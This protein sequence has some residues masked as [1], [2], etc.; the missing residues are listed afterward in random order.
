[1]YSDNFIQL[2][3]N[4]VRERNLK[5]SEEQFAAI[6]YT[7]PSILIANAD[8][9]IDLNEKKFMRY[10]PA[11]MVEGDNDLK[12]VQMTDEYFKEVKYIVSNLGQWE[13]GFLEALKTQLQENI[14]ERN[15]IFQAMW[16]TADSSE[17]ISEAERLKIDEV[18]RK[19]GL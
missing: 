19:L 7:F 17:D 14:N 16:R 6:V 3:D 9:R 11:V 13:E 5:L 4:Y 15:A 18:A 2:K 1:M 12:D 8:G 10:L